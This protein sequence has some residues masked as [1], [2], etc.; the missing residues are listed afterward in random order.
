M[1]QPPMTLFV[2]FGE[3]AGVCGDLIDEPAVQPWGGLEL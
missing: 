2:V 1:N 3:I